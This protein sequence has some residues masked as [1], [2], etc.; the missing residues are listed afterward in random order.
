[1]KKIFL[2]SLLISLCVLVYA[3]IT[4]QGTSNLTTV[5]NSCKTGSNVRLKFTTTNA[6]GNNLYVDNVT[7]GEPFQ[8]DVAVLSINNIA[9]DTSYTGRG[10]APFKITPKVSFLNLGSENISSSF[11]VTMNVSPGGYTN[12]KSISSINSGALTEVIFDSLTITPQTYY[13]ATI[14]SQLSTDQN[15]S[16]DTIK[17][18]FIVEPGKS[19]VFMAFTSTTCGPCAANN[20]SLDAFIGNNFDKIVPIKYHVNWP[21]AGD[22]MNLENPTQ[23]ANR[24]SFYGVNAVPTCKVDG[25]LT[26][27]SGYGYSTLNPLLI[28]RTK[29]QPPLTLKVTDTRVAGDSIKASIT[30]NI[31]TALPAGTYSLKVEAIERAIHYS[32]A[33]GSNGEKD[34]YDVFRKAFPDENGLTMPTAVGTYNYQVTYWKKT[35][36]VD[37]MMYTVVY[38]QNN[39]TKE[40]IN[41]A[42]SIEETFGLASPMYSLKGNGSLKY[43]N[44]VLI[45]GGIDKLVDGGYNTELFEGLFPASGWTIENPDAGLTWEQ[46]NGANGPTIGGS[47]AAKMGFYDYSGSGQQDMMYSKIYNNVSNSDSI[48]FNWAYAQYPGYS[49][50]L[51]IRLSLDGGA[52]YPFTVFDKSGADLATAPSTSSNFTPNSPSQWK[53]FAFS[54]ASYVNIQKINELIP[55]KYELNQN[56]PN[57]FNPVTKISFA[58]PKNGKVSLKIY[59]LN[60]KLVSTLFD[61][62]QTAGNYETS[63]N[64]SNLASGVYFYRLVSDNFT[65]TKKM[66]LT[67]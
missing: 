20:P 3:F 2:F 66:I 46:F 18:G 27:V 23:I 15:K 55:T 21:Q 34:F 4:P 5:N 28:Q 13:N 48:R 62:M 52:T 17:V 54:I 47:R 32:S 41:S 25:I 42:K 33:P 51:E 38:F 44:P 45:N 11:N 24:V 39:S 1:M 8:K 59:D 36:W 10:L 61:G 31:T 12:T 19:V 53:K 50:R 35:N 40:I 63:F 65:E 14:I 29:I 49:D 56:Y 67:K 43:V 64:G 6:Y 16:N 30:L 26:Q 22:P 60:G 57:P 9:K 7:V 58:I 37:S